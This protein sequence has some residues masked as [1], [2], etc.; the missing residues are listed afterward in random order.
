MIATSTSGA[1]ARA[2]T[3]DVGVVNLDTWSGCAEGVA[4]IALKH[5][6]HQLVLNPPGRIGRDAELA[7]KLDVGHALLA[8]GE[9]MHGAKPYPHR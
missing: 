9:Q 3:A 1:F 2:L 8:L 7:A 6:L 4:P 5:D